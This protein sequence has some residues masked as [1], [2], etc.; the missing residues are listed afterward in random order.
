MANQVESQAL[1]DLPRRSSLFGC[2]DKNKE[3]EMSGDLSYSNCAFYVLL[4]NKGF[5]TI[6]IDFFV[7]FFSFYLTCMNLETHKKF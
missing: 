4:E 6:K 3:R 2:I 7:S 5:C 1:P